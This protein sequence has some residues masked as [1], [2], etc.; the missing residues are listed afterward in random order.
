LPL[1]LTNQLASEYLSLSFIKLFCALRRERV[2][3][4]LCD[5][6]APGCCA[7][8]GEG[9]SIAVRDAV[10]PGR[11]AAGLFRLGWQLRGQVHFVVNQHVHAHTRHA[12]IS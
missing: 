10:L 7:S 1:S 2:R 8:V 11:L 4:A 5:A 12:S 6:L 9:A 3:D